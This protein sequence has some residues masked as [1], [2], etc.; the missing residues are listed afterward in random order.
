MQYRMTKIHMISS[1]LMSIIHPL[2]E[3]MQFSKTKH[4]LEIIHS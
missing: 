3:E 1:Y 2:W 4:D